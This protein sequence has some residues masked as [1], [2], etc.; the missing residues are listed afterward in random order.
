LARPVESKSLDHLKLG[1][2]DSDG[3]EVGLASILEQLQ[4]LGTDDDR[5]DSVGMKWDSD[6]PPLLPVIRSGATAIARWG[7]KLVTRVGVVTALLSPASRPGRSSP[8]VLG[9]DAIAAAGGG[10][11]ARRSS[12][13]RQNPRRRHAASETSN[14]Y[15]LTKCCAS[16]L[17]S[18]NM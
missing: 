12:L 6:T 15:L 2:P 7:T 4:L 11:G 14:T 3:H 5:Y 10:R 13:H 1:S 9:P 16:A 8:G 18:V 17:M